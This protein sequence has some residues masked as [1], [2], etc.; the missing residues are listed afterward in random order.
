MLK[1]LQIE[2]IKIKRYRTFWAILGIYALIF[3]LATSTMGMMVPENPLYSFF[4]FPDVWHN[5]AYVA[6]F[7]NILPGILI[8]M[9]ISNEYTYKTFRQ[10]LIDGL[11]RKELIYSKF[12]LMATISFGCVSFIFLWGLLRGIMTGHFDLISEIYQKVS[13]LFYLFI[14]MVGYMSLAALMALIFKVLV[15]SQAQRCSNL[16]PLV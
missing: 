7:L 11:S 8:I 5:L 16:S 13:F 10:N 3:I 15:S 12:I 14:Q 9:L 6:S 4:A 1:L 2:F